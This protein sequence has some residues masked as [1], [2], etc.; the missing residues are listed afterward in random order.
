VTREV[1]LD[2][3]YLIAATNPRD[4]LHARARAAFPALGAVRFVT[5]DAVLAEFLGY[6][7]RNVELRRRALQV[8]DG[9]REHPA[10]RIF[11]FGRTGFEGALRRYR[12]R[13]DKT[14]SLVDCHSMVLME[15]RDITRV[16][17]ADDHFRQAGFTC[18][19]PTTGKS[20]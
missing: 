11:H 18:L 9:L 10:C 13:P 4:A 8:V 6:T 3:S 16:L 17:T 14:Y 1:F 20:R 15:E 12:A 19:L 5:T 2:T 7:A